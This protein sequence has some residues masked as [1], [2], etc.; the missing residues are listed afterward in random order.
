MG[1]SLV[2]VMVIEFIMAV[3]QNEAIIRYE[4]IYTVCIDF[5]SDYIHKWNVLAAN[6]QNKDS[7]YQGI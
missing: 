2:L 1:V 3:P 7:L 5:F 4:A 6:T